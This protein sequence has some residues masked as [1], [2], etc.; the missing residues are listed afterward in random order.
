[1]CT[2][3]CARVSKCTYCKSFENKTRKKSQRVFSAFGFA[4]FY[5]LLMDESSKSKSFPSSRCVLLW[6]FRLFLGR[7]LESRKPSFE[8]CSERT[9]LAISHSSCIRT[10]ILGH[11]FVWSSKN[12]W[13]HGSHNP[14]VKWFSTDSTAGCY[15]CNL[16]ALQNLLA[17][18]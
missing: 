12:L 13:A 6:F 4:P 10:I 16:C 5:F 3:L 9:H 1:M 15:L 8:K 14:C 7:C 18:A 11:K 2:R 17:H